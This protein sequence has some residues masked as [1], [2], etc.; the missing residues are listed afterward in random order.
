M[1]RAGA[2]LDARH[3]PPAARS[4]TTSS[5]RPPSL[6]KACAPSGSRRC[7]AARRARA[8]RPAPASDAWSAA[9][10]R[11]PSGRPRRRARPVRPRCCA[12]PRPSPAAVAPRRA[13]ARR[14]RR[15]LGVRG[16]QCQRLAGGGRPPPGE[17]GEGGEAEADEG[18]AIA[19]RCLPLTAPGARQ[20]PR[21]R[22]SEHD[23]A[24]V[25]QRAVEVVATASRIADAAATAEGAPTACRVRRRRSRRRAPARR[26]ALEHSVRDEDDEPSSA[27][28]DARHRAA[29]ETGSSTA[30]RT[31]S[32]AARS[33]SP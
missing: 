6:T 32:I 12:D 14:R 21:L 3:D 13:R 24:G 4:T 5:P 26:G 16:G 7:S 31:R 23:H 9:T 30:R 20:V 29:E 25:A 2:D 22:A 28:G 10:R 1:A 19:A 18:P 11:R 17:G 8:A 33:S 27:D 15:G